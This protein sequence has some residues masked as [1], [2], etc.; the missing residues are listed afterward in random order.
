LQ[1]HSLDAHLAL[2]ARGR[3]HVFPPPPLHVTGYGGLFSE[4]FNHVWTSQAM[5]SMSEIEK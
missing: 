4:S 5:L 2:D 1:F 3:R